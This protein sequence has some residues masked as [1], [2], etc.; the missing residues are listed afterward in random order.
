MKKELEIFEDFIGAKNLRK[1]LQRRKIIETF[2]ATEKHLSLDELYKLVRHKDK[3][4]GYTTIYRTMKLLAECGLCE[5]A[6]FGEGLVRYEHKY[7]HTHHDHLVCTKC[8]K[9]IEVLE[10]ALE[11]MQEEL[12]RKHGFKPLKH[13]LQIF[14]LCKKCAE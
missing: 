4:I 9:F 2:L 6:D 10:P 3:N 7:A 13:K 8:G 14:G 5:E 12:A 1:T 11:K